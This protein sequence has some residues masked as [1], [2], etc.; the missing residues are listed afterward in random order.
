MATSIHALLE[1]QCSPSQDSQHT[2]KNERLARDGASLVSVECWAGGR[3]GGRAVVF[4]AHGDARGQAEQAGPRRGE[5]ARR[6]RGEDLHSC[7]YVFHCCFCCT[8]LLILFRRRPARISASHEAPRTR[9]LEVPPKPAD[10][11]EVK[12]PHPSFS[13]PHDP[14]QPS[15]HCQ[16]CLSGRPRQRKSRSDYVDSASPA[17]RPT[18]WPR[19][20]GPGGQTCVFYLLALLWYSCVFVLYCFIYGL[21]CL[22]LWTI[23]MFVLLCYIWFSLFV[24]VDRV[25]NILLSICPLALFIC[26]CALLSYTYIH[27]CVHINIHMLVCLLLWTG[28]AIWATARP[29]AAAASP[30]S[31]WPERRDPV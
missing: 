4:R 28:W 7:C 29:T 13:E 23:H 8:C 11:P 5:P 2:V 10:D 15:T 20:R 30:T 31:T 18:R 16:E 17:A 21:V 1:L 24:S 6:R 19:S 22:L 26:M 12:A 27:I 25:G 9:G 14:H 3:F